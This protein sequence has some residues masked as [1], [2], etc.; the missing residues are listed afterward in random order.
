MTTANLLAQLRLLGVRLW[1]DGDRLRYAAP[2]GIMTPE[3]RAELGRHKA[4]IIDHLQ[5]S[6]AMVRDSA[7]AIEPA[8]PGATIPLSFAQERVWF[9]DQLVPGNPLFNIDAAIRLA[10]PLNQALL[11]RSINE[12]V[13]RHAVLRTTFDTVAGHPV[14]VIAPVANVPLPLLDLRSL[15][16]AA[17]EAEATRLATEE[18]RRPF[19]LATGPVLRTS[20]LQLG[21]ADYV[22]LLT[23]H[24]IV[25]DGWS[26]EIFFSELTAA[27]QA[28]LRG[29]PSP[30]PELPI[31]YAD[32]ALWQRTWLQG[33]ALDKL[34]A[35]WKR[36]LTDLPVLQLPTDR[37]RPAFETYRGAHLQVSVPASLKVAAER[38]ARQ[39]GVTLYMVL[40]A[41]F[42]ALLA[43]YAGQQDIVV[44]TYIAGRNRAEIEPLIGFFINTLVLRTDL[45]GNPSF[46]QLLAR[47]RRTTLDAY[48]NQ[49]V[50]FPRL[51][52]ALQPE[53]NLSRNPLFQV[54]FQLYNVPSGQGQAAGGSQSVMAIERGTAIFDLVFS[55]GEDPEGLTG[56]FEYNTD[57]F[58][59]PTVERM[60][61]HYARLLHAASASPDTPLSDLAILAPDE[62]EQLVRGWNATH[63]ESGAG[64]S[65]AERFDAQAARTPDAPAFICGDEQLSFLQLQQRANQ[66]AHL[67]RLRQVGPETL[68]GI[69]LDRSLEAAVALLGVLKAGAAYLPLD[70][71]YPRERL[72][73]MLADAR[74]PVV[75]TLARHRELLPGS[76]RTICLDADEA[77]LSAQSTAS[78]PVHPDPDSL[79]YAI[80]TSG[81]TGRPKGVAVPHRQI[82]NRLQWMWETY[83]FG[84]DEVNCQKTALSFVDSIWEYFGAL[85]QGI[86]TVIIP[87]EVLQDPYALV[88][89]LGRHRVSRIW[90]VPSFLRMLLDAYP[91]L[92]ERLPQLRFWVTSGEALSTE[93]YGQFSQLVPQGRL[94]YLYGT[95]D[96]W[97]VTWY[98]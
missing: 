35:Y 38:L 74:V 23:M 56:S 40:L 19:D 95:S 98:D 85:L 90:L 5:Q 50:P 72:A 15:S 37:P 13:R 26:M 61:D 28:F 49:D 24:H 11:E 21:D 31:Q 73:F 69:Y 93:L 62:R 81:S 10:L 6:A 96:V 91:D 39:E 36:Q 82:L 88:E 54:V 57:L 66:L 45:G 18:A 20:L 75:V 30:L 14:Q 12:V 97:D 1:L 34:L 87:D 27:Y 70:P 65:L 4:A 79:A 44:G 47:V 2:P 89:L 41:A 63:G 33:P 64:R 17:R 16:G 9:M 71:S 32:Y 59:Q 67:L 22:L 84:S 46:R 68:V 86:P 77:L 29:L 94:Y 51:V 43:R 76:A 83:P 78:P 53:R 7:P 8:P 3:L 80:Y 52:E 58:D 55:L 92:A 60:F 42:K 25:S 48:A